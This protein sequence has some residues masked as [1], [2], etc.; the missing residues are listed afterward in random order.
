ME[1]VKTHKVPIYTRRAIAN[2]KER[3]GDDHKEM[4]KRYVKK[5]YM[6][7]HY[8]EDAIKFINNLYSFRRQ[9]KNHRE[10]TE[11]TE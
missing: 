9:I 5:S 1:V 8:S 6:T 2:Y 11:P 10:K 7:N 4:N 3:L